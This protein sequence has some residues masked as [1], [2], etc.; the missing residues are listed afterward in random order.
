MARY[1]G[2]GLALL[3]AASASLT[4]AEDSD[5]VKGLK[6]RIELLEA[7]LKLAELENDRLKAEVA[8]LGG[9]PAAKVAKKSLSDMLVAETVL[10]GNWRARQGRQG[11]GDGGDA[12]LTITSRDGKK[13]EGRFDGAR[14][15][16]RHVKFEFS[17]V[18]TT[19][20]RVYATGSVNK[21]VMTGVVRGNNLEL[22]YTND[23]NVVAQATF[24][25][26][27]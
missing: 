7:K 23:M 5:E 25:L 4:R 22:S 3:I 8:K 2:L 12:V 13:I 20:L 11:A 16:N 6:A 24:A 21:F 1:I 19:V 14:K 10:K 17:G 27:K 26:P 15:D 18:V 9:K